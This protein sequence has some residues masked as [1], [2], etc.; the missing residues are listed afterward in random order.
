MKAVKTLLI[1][2]PVSVESLYGKF[3]RSG[4]DLPPLSLGYIAS[5]LIKHGKEVQILDSAKLRFSLGDILK[6]IKDYCPDVIGFHTCTPY[7]NTVKSLA[8]RIREAYPEILLIAGGPHFWGSAVTDL[9]SMDLDIIVIGEGEKT[10]LKTV[11]GLER[12]HKDEFLTSAIED[13]KGVVYMKNGA[14]VMNPLREP[15]EDIDNIPYPA[16]HLLPPLHTYRVSAVQYR[17]LPSTAMVTSRGCP[18]RCIF[19]VCS[20]FKQKVR[21]HSVEYVIGEVDELIN[22]YHMKDI[23]FVDDVFTLNRKRTY[24]MCDELSKRKKKL[25]WSCNV[26]VGMVDKDTLQYM[27]DSGCWMVMVGIESGNREI[28]SRIR[29]DIKLEEAEELSQWCKEIGLMLHPNFILGH[30]GETMETID[31][32]IDFAKKLYAHFPLFSIMTPYPGTELWNM[33]ENYGK[34]KKDNFDHF[35]FGSDEPCFIPHGLTAE[36]LLKKRK[37]AY[38]K[39]Y[40]NLPMIKRHLQSLK[41]LEDVKRLFDAAGILIGL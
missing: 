4:S 32:T 1:N 41:S 23:T 40:L 29:K 19:C 16:R 2:P 6:A 13:I 20:L 21:M 38:R 34:L 37:E 17:K 35:S 7:F 22:R 26:R 24:A 14:G 5:Y 12:C 8:S 39:C 11:E 28:L 31:Q 33:A 27:K 3:A 9:E 30:P 18:F 15:V 10:C 25:V 36:L